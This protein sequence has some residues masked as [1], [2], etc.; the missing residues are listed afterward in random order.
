MI[1]QNLT[2][3][4]ATHELICRH[5]CRWTKVY[6][7]RCHVLKTTASGKLKI[8]VFGERN[9]KNKEHI[10]RIRYVEADRVRKRNV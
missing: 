10:S 8:L 9:W 7:M 3:D 6:V 2:A 1:A 5:V 4:N